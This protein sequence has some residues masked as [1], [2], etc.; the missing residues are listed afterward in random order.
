MLGF[1][2]KTSML[3]FSG[4]SPALITFTST[5]HVQI[6]L[7]CRANVHA[8][9]HIMPAEHTVPPYMDSAHCIWLHLL[10]YQLHSYSFQDPTCTDKSPVNL[11]NTGRHGGITI[12]RN[13]LSSVLH[14]FAGAL[15][16]R[17]GLCP[18]PSWL[19]H[20]VWPN[21]PTGMSEK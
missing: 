5:A 16:I 21:S 11:W 8:H 12:T 1:T 20:T 3:E 15:R 17:L 14:H 7:N 13:I 10:F 4:P 19:W 2:R 9:T 18:M 6:P